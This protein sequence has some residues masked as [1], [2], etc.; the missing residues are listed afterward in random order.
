MDGIERF[1]T[2]N[3]ILDNDAFIPLHGHDLDAGYDLRTPKDFTIK[4]GGSAV[5]DLG[6]HFE[7]PVGWY[8]KL[9]SKSGLNVNHGIVSL[10]GIIDSGYT[11]SVVAKIY[12]FGKEPYSF[13]RGDKIVQIIFQPHAAPRMLQVYY[14]EPT[15][16]GSSGF[17]STGK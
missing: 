12:N 8:G 17:G 11:G 4:P 6:V 16:R 7:I 1:E 5:I 10:G 3:I 15:E 2:I 9:E 13:K 14:F